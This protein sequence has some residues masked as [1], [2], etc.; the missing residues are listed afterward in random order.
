MTRILSLLGSVIWLMPHSPLK[1]FCLRRLGHT[2]ASTA[3][4]RPNLVLGCGVF[5]IGEDAVLSPFNVFRGVARVELG[6]GAFIGR[7]NQFTA[8]PAYQ[9][10][11]ARCGALIVGPEAIITNRHYF[12]ASG[13]IELARR[14]AV[15]G[16]RSIFQSHEIDL[17]ADETTVGVI[18]IGENAMLAT[19][20]LVLKD[21]QVPGY[22][23]V[24]AGSTVTASEPG[25][26]LPA[27][28]YAGSPARWRK[29]LPDCKWWHREGYFTPV[30][31]V[32]DI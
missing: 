5:I 7:F 8:A 11:S 14:A 23:I 15:G 1:V 16:I 28:L 20:C 9:A 29:D 10:F 21:A 2:V 25:R 24:A 4:L 27:G 26:E 17:V 19:G 32:A 3:R 18:R 22:S 6:D 31:K 30:R 12:D 13:R